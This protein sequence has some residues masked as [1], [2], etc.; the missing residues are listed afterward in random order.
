MYTEYPMQRS[1]RYSACSELF[2]KPR[3][4]VIAVKRAFIVSSLLSTSTSTQELVT[5][6]CMSFYAIAN[7]DVNE[8][9]MDV[10]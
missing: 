10:H 6:V 3:Y 8:W 4:Y 7:A 2:Y 9:I 5:F 1:A